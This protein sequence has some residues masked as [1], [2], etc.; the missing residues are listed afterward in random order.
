[1]WGANKANGKQAGMTLIENNCEIVGDVHFSD[2]LTVNGFVKGNIVAQSTNAKV[3]VSEK[4]KVKGE[5]RVPSVVS[6]GVI[7]GDIHSEKH[8]VLDAKSS[9]TGNVYYNTIEMVKG[10]RVYG[11]LVHQSN[12]EK[13]VAKKITE[14]PRSE[15]IV[16]KVAAMS[17]KAP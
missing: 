4:G 15:P 12:A 14:P 3:T 17:D 13:A 11:N 6:N 5:I 7:N 9:V 1:M 2:K 10:S 8:I 16:Q